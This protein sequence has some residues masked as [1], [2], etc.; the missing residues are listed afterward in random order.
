MKPLNP[1]QD[2][3]DPDIR[4]GV[5]PCKLSNSL[6]WLCAHLYI[7]FLMTD[8]YKHHW[9]HSNNLRWYQTGPVL[10]IAGERHQSTTAS[11]EI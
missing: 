6:P 11:L 2:S 4:I 1:L 10:Q 8:F 5:Y 3:F 9:W 7:Y